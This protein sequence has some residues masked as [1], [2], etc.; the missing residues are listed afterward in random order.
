MCETSAPY[1][2]ETLGQ[3]ELKAI[4]NHRKPLISL[5]L[6]KRRTL[7]NTMPLI[8][9]NS[10]MKKAYWNSYHCGSVLLQEGKKISSKLCRARWCIRCN[11]IKTAELING[12][13][14]L[15]EKFQA[16]HLVVVTMKNCK[17]RELKSQHIKMNE[18]FQQCRWKIDRKHGIK[19]NGIRTWE[20]TYNMERD[21]YHPHFNVL[22]DT[23]EGATLFLRYWMEY[24]Q[25][26]QGFKSV[27]RGGQ[28]VKEIEG[29]KGL[30]EVFKY[31]TK[32]SVS[33]EEEHKAQDWIYQCVKGKRLAQPFGN[34]R[35]VKIADDKTHQEEVEALA[36]QIDIWVWEK[37]NKHYVNSWGEMLVTEE[38]VEALE[39]ELKIEK[40]IRQ[41][42]KHKQHE[43]KPK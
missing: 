19:I 22:I 38:E 30:L 9:L 31:T 6:N 37:E 28:S 23:S 40:Q 29:V 33:H 42:N 8:D 15:F 13:K 35:K 21:D 25:K 18:A 11:R 24:W 36:N 7:E 41:Q 10:S 26:K 16:P 14:H 2:L 5:V 1:L 4:E 17:G 39:S 27:N 3:V 12:Y 43:Y 34:L 20:C 32:L